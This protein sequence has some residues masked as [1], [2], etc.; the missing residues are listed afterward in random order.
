MLF[1]SQLG[2][3]SRPLARHRSATPIQYRANVPETEARRMTNSEAKR[4]IEETPL[5]AIDSREWVTNKMSIK[6][7]RNKI[8]VIRT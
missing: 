3:S 7:R 5:K 2:A 8:E 1:C 4:T 6:V